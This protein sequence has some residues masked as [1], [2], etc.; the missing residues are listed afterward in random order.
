MY[1]RSHFLDLTERELRRARRYGHPLSILILNVD[2][3]NSDTRITPP[4]IYTQ[5]IKS[6]AERLLR[7]TREPDII[8]R[9]ADREFIFA[10]PETNSSETQSVIERLH[11][12]LTGTPIRTEQ[13]PIDVA[14]RMADVTTDGGVSDLASLIDTTQAALEEA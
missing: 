4:V 12:C 8:G 2:C 6:V 7:F 1:N 13:G 3:V 14:I 9:F 5:V 11:E 10:L